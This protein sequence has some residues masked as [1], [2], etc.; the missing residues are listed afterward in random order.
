MTFAV[1]LALNIN[2]LITLLTAWD[3]SC[4]NKPHGL[5][6]EKD[7]G[8]TEDSWKTVRSCPVI[9]QLLLIMTAIAVVASSVW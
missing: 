8:D 4:S 6:W 3:V 7:H 5:H 2:Y 9:S 1:A